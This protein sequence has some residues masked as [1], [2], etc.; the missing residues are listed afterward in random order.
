MQSFL[1]EERY[2]P[3]YNW[4]VMSKSPYLKKNEQ[5]PVNWLEWSTEGFDKAQREGKL[6]LISIGDH[7]CHLSADM[8][9][10]SQKDGETV[11]LLNDKFVCMMVDKEERP[12]IASLYLSKCQK[13][14]GK[15]KGPLNIFLNSDQEI[16]YAAM[17][18]PKES[19]VDGIIGFK[20]LITQVYDQHV[21]NRD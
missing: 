15:G 3:T 6:V 8:E 16:L 4:L 9:Q 19:L 5:S 21:I 18:L 12:D 20:E 11:Q 2:S 14:E 10:E 7:H 17:Y 13:L 1:S